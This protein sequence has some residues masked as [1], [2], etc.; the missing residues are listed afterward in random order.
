MIEIAGLNLFFFVAQ[1]LCRIK[2]CYRWL[3]GHPFPSTIDLPKGRFGNFPCIYSR[4]HSGRLLAICLGEEQ[5]QAN[6]AT[7]YESLDR[8]QRT[9]WRDEI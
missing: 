3:Y 6:T 5:P 9:D 1:A 8:K 4:A 2:G 7:R